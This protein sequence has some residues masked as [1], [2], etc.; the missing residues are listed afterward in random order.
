NRRDMLESAPAR[1]AVSPAGGSTHPLLHRSQLGNFMEQSRA[2][3]NGREQAT[4]SRRWPLRVQILLPH[5]T[6]MVAVLLAVSI[7]NAFFATLHSQRQIEQQ[8]QRIANT[9]AKSAFPLSDTVLR[10][11]SGLSGAEFILTDI[12]GN[13]VA[14]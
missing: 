8:L 11:V 5:A 2:E 7:V 6:L 9:L 4:P 13:L 3:Q 1:D 10:Q 14:S 12:E